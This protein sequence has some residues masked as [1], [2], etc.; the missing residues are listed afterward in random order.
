MGPSDMNS[1]PIRATAV[2]AA[3]ALA[4]SAALACA[5]GCQVFDVGGTPLMAMGHGGVAFVEY[6]YMDQTRN[7]AGTH[8]APGADNE[9]KQIRSNFVVAG[10][11]YMF[12]N[13][14]GVMV[15]VPVTNRLFRTENETDTAVD[16]FD[17]TAL[18][19]IRVQG[20]YTGLSP[21]MSTGL[22]F[23]VKLPT[24]DWKYTGFDRDTAIGSGSTDILFGGHHVGS[25]G[26]DGA[27]GWF[28]QGQFDIPVAT[29]GDYRP[30]DEFDGAVGVSYS[31]WSSGD[32]RFRLS[33][34]LQ[35]IGSARAKDGGG[36]ADPPNSGYG[37]ILISPGL[38][39]DAG[40]WK[41]YGDVE[42]P[43]YQ[44]LNGSQLTAPALFK[45]IVSRRF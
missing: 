12:N 32:G 37:R 9:D 7:M 18:G 19:D 26:K 33:P 31:A 28:V 15:E 24:G 39:L 21:D 23:G 34:V 8:S 6:D 42:F 40:A 22:T 44:D 45:V 1:F 41:L 13:D 30:G 25:F 5:C 14:W 4:P 17:H 3:F 20:V 38:Q 11:Q 10:V 36:E 35:V 43:V 29:Q 16:A 2:A 27:W